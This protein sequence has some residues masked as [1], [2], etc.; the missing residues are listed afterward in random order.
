MVAEQRIDATAL[1]AA[2][3]S[4]EVTASAVTETLLER[5]AEVDGSI[6]SHTVIRAEQ[7]RAHAQSVDDRLRRGEHVGPLAGVPVSIKDVIWTAGDLATA[8]SRVTQNFVPDVDARMVERMH[9]AD[10]I[11]AGKTNVSEL[12][13]RGV[14]KNHVFGTTLNPWDLTKTSGGSSGG[15][16]AA[17]AAGLEPL[18]LGSDGGGSIR[19]PAAFCGIAGIKPTHGRV[20]ADPGFDGWGSLTDYGVLA[21]STRDLRLGLSIVQDDEWA[22]RETDLAASRPPAERARI[23]VSADLGYAPLSSEVRTA[24]MSQIEQLRGDGLEIREVS[25]PG[26]DPI[27]WWTTLAAAEGYAA[28]R[29]LLES[30]REL[31]EPV[32]VEMLE[33]GIPITASDYLDALAWQRAYTAQWSRLFEDYDALLCPATQQSAFDADLDWPVELDGN[34]MPFPPMGWAAL[35]LPANL[36]GQPAVSIPGG[37]T[38][39]GLPVGLQVIG[40]HGA[41]MY[42]LRIAELLADVIGGAA[43]SPT[44]PSGPVRSLLESTV[45]R[46]GAAS[47]DLRH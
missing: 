8:G 34:R 46:A 13:F 9:R 2:V 45:A 33:L 10:G 20:P 1:A 27:R 14:T 5:I 15:A 28:N 39:S 35:C 31:L 36:T 32:T 40:A 24:F 30:S 12:C 21:V 6:N 47:A 38:A 17:V 7:A 41:D 37:L 44:L 18:A 43:T 23:A 26:G 42:T 16:A 3:R 11:V 22:G 29:R 25:V 19:M 4:G